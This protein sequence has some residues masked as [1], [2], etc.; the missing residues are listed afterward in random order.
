[1]QTYCEIANTSSPMHPYYRYNIKMKVIIGLGNPEPEYSQTRHNAGK[2][3]LNQFKE[4][5]YSFHAWEHHKKSNCDYVKVDDE[6]YMVKPTCFMNETGKWVKTFLDYFNLK[7]EDMIVAYDELDLFVGEY[8]FLF[9]KGTRIHNGV[10]SIAE[11]LGTDQFWHLRIGVRDLSIP[12]S[13][14]KAGRD[15][16]RYVLE[17]FNSDDSKKVNFLVD[18]TIIPAL[19]KFLS[20]N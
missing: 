19:N 12:M 4:H 15:P 7:S 18:T 13:V 3:L 9:A 8:K 2:E 6:F 11:V 1:M 5:S 10:N 16:S 17:R 14:Q 20:K